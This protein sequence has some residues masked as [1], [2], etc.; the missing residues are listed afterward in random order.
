LQGQEAAAD[1]AS[2][3]L[4][5]KAEYLVIATLFYSNEGDMIRVE[6][7]TEHFHRLKGEKCK[8]CLVTGFFLNLFHLGP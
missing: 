4:A 3:I 5:V 8:K 2:Y 6:K 1:L 7:E